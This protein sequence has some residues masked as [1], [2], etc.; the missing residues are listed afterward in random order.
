M[1]DRFRFAGSSPVLT[2]I[3]V[4]NSERRVVSQDADWNQLDGGVQV[5]A[6]LDPG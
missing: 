2:I 1:I 5:L 6:I 4:D 3:C